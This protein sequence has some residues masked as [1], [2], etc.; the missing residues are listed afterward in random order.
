MSRLGTNILLGLIFILATAFVFI[1]S[2]QSQIEDSKK[3]EPTVTK[4][5]L[6]TKIKNDTDDSKKLEPSATKTDLPSE[7]KDKVEDTKKPESDIFKT[8]FPWEGKNTMD[9][10]ANSEPPKIDPAL[11]A[12][13]NAELK[14]ANK[15]YN[16]RKFSDS[17]KHFRSVADS[18]A[19][20]GEAR[21]QAGVCLY[22]MK[23]YDAALKEYMRA[24]KDAKFIS[25][26]HKAEDSART[27]DCCM[28]GICPANCLKRSSPGWHK[29]PGDDTHI[30]MT[31]NY[32]DHKTGK[33][34]SK[35]FSNA[36][37]GDVIVFENG[38][39]QDKGKC[40][41]CHGT[42]HVSFPQ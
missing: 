8:D 16:T 27:L 14:L 18:G 13:N 4:T 30:W 10:S 9:D 2:V 15:L 39:P 20:N 33:H 11:E 23:N 3:L 31:F 7:T 42:G 35:S 36:H 22:Q 6:P 17:L 1:N 12:K 40:P 29:M 34:G 38:V 26:Q 32:T 41:I 21:I 5:G 19:D 28:R 37:I 25:I 24:A